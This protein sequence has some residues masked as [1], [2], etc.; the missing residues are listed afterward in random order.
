[1]GGFELDQGSATRGSEIFFAFLVLISAEAL[2]LVNVKG[3]VAFYAPADNKT[4][5]CK[6]WL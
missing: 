6:C 1:M 3:N 5:D 4:V 2:V